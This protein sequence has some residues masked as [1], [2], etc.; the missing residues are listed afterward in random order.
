MVN[1]QIKNVSGNESRSALHRCRPGKHKRLLDYDIYA[2]GILS[3]NISIDL[4]KS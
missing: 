1:I 3:L 4:I 2:Q